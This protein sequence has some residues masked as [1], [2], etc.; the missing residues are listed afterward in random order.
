MELGYLD[1][2][3]EQLPPTVDR[4]K[5]LAQLTQM[6]SFY[7][8]QA[9]P[10]MKDLPSRLGAA[11]AFQKLID[12]SLLRLKGTSQ[13]MEVKCR[14][15]C[16]HCCKIQVIVSLCEAQYLLA[17]AEEQG[18]T[19]D[20]DLLQKQVLIKDSVDYMFASK[21]NRCVFLSDQDECRV[22]ESRPVTCRKYMV[23]TDPKYCSADQGVQKVATV[24]TI[25]EDMM[26]MG[27]LT[28]DSERGTLS[29][30]LLRA[31]EL[32]KTLQNK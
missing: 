24:A 22:Y 3:L 19:I 25:D 5:L 32:K 26:H 14:K 13:M 21:V 10:H 4:N 8:D 1:R 27:L 12:N 6:I 9:D 23:V 28:A 16:G 29:E 11:R 15:G 17:I 7:K 20:E 2:I 18:I 31:L 30:M